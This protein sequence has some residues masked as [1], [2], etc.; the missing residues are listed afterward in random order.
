MLK[1]L[2]VIELLEN[3]KILFF[4]HALS[5]YI[6]FIDSK[7]VTAAMEVDVKIDPKKQ[8]PGLK[9]SLSTVRVNQKVKKLQKKSKVKRGRVVKKKR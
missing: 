4:A 6:V 7:N 9:K 1:H 8:K 5:L 3:N 2:S